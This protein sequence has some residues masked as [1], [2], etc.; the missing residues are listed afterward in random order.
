MNHAISSRVFIPEK[1]ANLHASDLSGSAPTLGKLRRSIDESKGT[2]CK[3]Q[4]SFPLYHDWFV[5]MFQVTIGPAAQ[6]MK[7]CFYP[8]R[9]FLGVNQAFLLKLL[10]GTSGAKFINL[11]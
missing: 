3:R 4:R 2:G 11:I 1:K 9:L 8:S 10:D 5:H 6:Q 7:L